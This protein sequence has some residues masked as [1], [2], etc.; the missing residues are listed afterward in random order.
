MI[1]PLGKP[2][3][4]ENRRPS[5]PNINLTVMSIVVSEKKGSSLLGNGCILLSFINKLLSIARW[6][7]GLLPTD[8]GP[9]AGALGGLSR[10][11]PRGARRDRSPGG[12]HNRRAKRSLK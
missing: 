6:S 7:G 5:T 9:L 12:E 3:T 4:V 1:G 8:A 10:G 11:E 2:L